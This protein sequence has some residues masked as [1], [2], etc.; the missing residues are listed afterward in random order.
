MGALSRFPA[1]LFSSQ[2]PP[3]RSFGFFVEFVRADSG[4]VQLGPITDGA[5]GLIAD[6]AAV[7]MGLMEKGGDL[8][9]RQ[10]L[11]QPNPDPAPA[12]EPSAAAFAI[13]AESACSRMPG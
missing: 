6:P 7:P 9:G 11:T 13:R 2:C 8:R 10:S 12:R 4:G 3:T 1:G 5:R